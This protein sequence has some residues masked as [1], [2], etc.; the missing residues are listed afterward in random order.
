M[1]SCSGHLHGGCSIVW[2]RFH[3]GGVMSITKCSIHRHINL[4]LAY[5]FISGEPGRLRESARYD[6]RGREA[7]G[8]VPPAPTQTIITLAR[9]PAALRDLIRLVSADGRK[10]TSAPANGQTRH[11]V[12]AVTGSRGLL[13][14]PF[15][16]GTARAPRACDGLGHRLR[17]VRWSH[18][19]RNREG[20][21][22]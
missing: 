5:D 16:Q 2:H 14:H 18:P 17:R 11:F 1:L 12:M 6:Q 19:G 21:V 9:G 22:S 7:G 4:A 8:S 15:P 20:D 3:G 13:W 10:P